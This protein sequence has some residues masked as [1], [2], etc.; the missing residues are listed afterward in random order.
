M[1]SFK[2]IIVLAA[3]GLIATGCSIKQDRSSCTTPISI[4][5]HNFR[6][7]QEDMYSTKATTGVENYN[8]LKALILAFYT[9]NGAEQYKAIQI[10]SDAST[11]ENF[12]EFSCSL[13]YG[14]YTMVAVGYYYKADQPFDLTSPTLAAYT[15]D[16]AYETFVSTQTFSILDSDPLSIYS[17]LER[18]NTTLRVISTDGK[19]ADVTNIRMTLAKGGRAFNPTTGLATV[20]S[21]FSNTV[22]VS[23]ATGSSTNSLTLFFL[24]SDEQTMDVTIE[25][26][27]EDQ[28]VLFSTTVHDVPFKRNRQTL[29]RGAMYSASTSVSGLLVDPDMLDGVTVE[30]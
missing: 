12:G 9:P 15:G 14:T 19:A 11:Y 23:A 30:F 27:N 22:G 21:G 20:N 1:K 4:Y 2:S 16:H 8:D 6:I 25:T 26:L 29:L 18:V 10:K 17:T 7:E 3:L 28:E 5:V 13:P 24:A